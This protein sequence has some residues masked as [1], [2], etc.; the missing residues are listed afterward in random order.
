MKTPVKKNSIPLVPGTD[1]ELEH[2]E[3]STKLEMPL[4]E[5]P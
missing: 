3:I 4:L 2:C 5:I 1:F